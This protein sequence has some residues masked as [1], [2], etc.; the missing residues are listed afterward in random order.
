[1]GLRV[2][3]HRAEG[4]RDRRQCETIGGGP[5]G[6]QEGTNL[7][8]ED[9]RQPLFGAFRQIVAAIGRRGAAIGVV[10]GR[11]NARVHAIDIVGCKV[12]EKPL[13]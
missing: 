5:G 7:L 12:H 3:E 11:E 8:L 4:R 1:M 10:K 2:A 6:H 13:V 9:F